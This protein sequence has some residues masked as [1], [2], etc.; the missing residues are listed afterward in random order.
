MVGTVL[1][2][3]YDELVRIWCYR[4]TALCTAIILFVAG[5]A[6]V[7]HMPNVYDSWAQIY[8]A[9]M[10]PLSQAAQNVSLGGDTYGSTYVV[11]KTLLNDESLGKVAEQLNP[12]LS[13]LA[14]GARQSAI[15]A[16]RNRIEISPDNGDGFTEFHYTATDAVR[17]YRVVQLLLNQFVAANQDRAQ[18]DLGQADVFL[19]AQIAVYQRKVAESQQKISAFRQRYGS[20][21][22]E[23]DSEEEAAAAADVDNARAVYNAALARDG[24]AAPQQS[25]I[26]ALEDRIAA[27]RLQYT[28]QYPDVIAA[29]QQLAQLQQRAAQG[30]KTG[31]D[32][33][34]A[35]AR[36]QL[37]AAQARLRRTRFR[38]NLPPQIATQEAELKRNDD[39]LRNSL[40]ELLSRREAAQMS[41]AVYGANNNAKFQVTNQPTIP[42]FPAGPN[43]ALLLGLAFLGAIAG[44]VGAAYLR[45][46]ITG[47]FVAP[48]ELED[49]FQLPVIGTISWEKTWHTGETVGG[50][51][52]IAVY[53]TFGVILL[54][55][56][57]LVSIYTSPW[58]QAIY[59]NYSTSLLQG[60]VR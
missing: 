45:G 42:A 28:D 56:T 23:T 26:A 8:V 49:A 59:H 60:F 48:R 7:V 53:V 4:W 16:L 20:S 15:N 30:S 1:T 17:A 11:Q 43:R 54:V 24:A 5:A 57:I 21:G 55:A 3:V 46:A 2:L 41:M 25:Q 38:P 52:N 44:G 39:M 51:R 12:A 14:P 27:L 47:V 40:Q 22:V 37:L 29:R 36:G 10:T 9:K 18:R 31:T 19:D 13:R 6:Y 32:P 35:S 33:A 34:I 50:S 58:L